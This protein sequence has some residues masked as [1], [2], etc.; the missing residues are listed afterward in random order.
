MLFTS[1]LV[2]FVALYSI[3]AQPCEI[4]CVECT[5]PR[6]CPDL[7]VSRTYMGLGMIL[8]TRNFAEDDCNVVEG[9]VGPGLQ[10]IL[11]FHYASPNIG[12]GALIV[13]DPRENEDW[14]D[15]DNCH[16]HC[17]FNQY[18][19][20]RL[21]TP[22][23]YRRWED[24]RLSNPDALSQDLLAN[25][26]DLL[27]ELLVGE[28][29]GFCV[30]EVASCDAF[31]PLMDCP[32]T[33]TDESLYPIEEFATCATNQGIGVGWADIYENLLDGQWVVV[34]PE[35]GIF[36]LEAEANAEKFFVER[37]YTNNFAAVCV[38]VPPMDEGLRGSFEPSPSCITPYEFFEAT[39]CQMCEATCVDLGWCSGEEDSEFPCGPDS[40][41]CG[42]ACGY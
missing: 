2:A 31:G 41:F 37:S 23:G 27:D 19:D 25:Q 13:G 5:D 15:C 16:D 10:R 4:G 30:G 6:G 34:P 22:A 14:F 36:M 40:C 18:A 29:L 38:N 24:I 32:L 42:G 21:W 20:Y 33:P 17:H 9:M 39:D 11:R 1:L 3:F 12:T 28:K 7:I 35:G 8:D 26:S